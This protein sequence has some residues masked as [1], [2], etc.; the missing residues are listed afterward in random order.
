MK[1]DLWRQWRAGDSIS[2][3]SR[4]LGKPPGSVFTVLKHHGGIA[5]A[6]RVRRAD[7]LSAEDRESI[8]RGV[9]TT[10]AQRC[11][12]ADAQLVDGLTELIGLLVGMHSEPRRAD[13]GQ[14][15]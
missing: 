11:V 1:V 9:E 2:V 4:A 15:Q 3:I 6:E 12:D 14:G 8:S 5:P 10:V 13:I 7:R